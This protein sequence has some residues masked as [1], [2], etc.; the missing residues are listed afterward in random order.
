[1]HIG[2]IGG[3]GPAAT[4]FYYRG[5][6]NAQVASPKP[7]DLTIVHAD[8]RQVV[9]NLSSNAKDR[10]AE[11]FAGHVE[12]LRGAGAEVAAVTSVAGHFCFRQLEKVSVLPLCSALGAIRQALDE[13]GIERIGLIGSAVAMQTSLY[14]TLSHLACLVPPGDELRQVGEQYMAMAGDQ[15]ATDAQRQL[16]FSSGNKLVSEQ[17]AD[18]VLLAGTDLFL[19]FDGFDPGFEAIDSAEIH[20]AAL[21]E[22]ARRESL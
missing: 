13:R 5:M 11:I 21:T 12:S 9:S 20:I 14:G 7:L 18:A 17:G 15:H 4:E 16:F 19:A 6:V 2:L 1:M 8:I 10:Q 3:I 22:L